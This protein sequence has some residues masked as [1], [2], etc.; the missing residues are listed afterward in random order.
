V[1]VA[2]A[3]LTVAV[4]EVVLPFYGKRK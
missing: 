2:V 4:E 1:A 3:V